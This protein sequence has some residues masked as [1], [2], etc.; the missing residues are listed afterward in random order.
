MRVDNYWSHSVIFANNLQKNKESTT[1]S[2]AEVSTG[3][4]KVDEKLSEDVRSI[5]SPEVPKSGAGSFLSFFYPSKQSTTTDSPA[6]QDLAECAQEDDSSVLAQKFE[7]L[8][9]A[10]K[11]RTRRRLKYE[12]LPYR[13]KLTFRAALKD[14]ML[15]RAIHALQRVSDI[16]SPGGGERVVNENESNAPSDHVDQ[17]KIPTA[18]I[19][20]MIAPS[21]DSQFIPNTLEGNPEVNDSEE[22]PQESPRRRKR[23]ER[24]IKQKIVLNTLRRKGMRFVTIFCD[25]QKVL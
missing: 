2:E 18:N 13:D 25:D 6:V 20:E 12:K 16:H 24:V 4:S 7:N 14:S 17:E 23:I 21:F 8:R 3:S 19:P 5:F 9:R 11:A 10:S 15:D 1:N 22:T